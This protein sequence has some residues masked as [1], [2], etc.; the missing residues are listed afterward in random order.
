MNSCAL[1]TA[2]FQVEVT[3]ISKH[4]VWLLAHEHE[5]FMS[6]E[7][8][9]WFR[10]VSVEKILNVEEPARG[11]YHWPQL[12]VDLSEEIILH[13]ERFPLQAK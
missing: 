12:D 7:K 10:N 5:L 11:D 2:T 6:Y 9:P 4:G 1:G 13:P 8:F 3:H